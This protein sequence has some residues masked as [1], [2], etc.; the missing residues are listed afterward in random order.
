M[1]LFAAWAVCLLLGW[2]GLLGCQ[3]QPALF[4]PA[5]DP[6]ETIYFVPVREKV[7]ALTFDDGP[8]EPA[9]GLILDALKRHQVKATFFLIGANVERY[10]ETARRIKAEGHLIGNHTA[11]HSMFDQ[12][13]AFAIAQDIAD[14]Q[15]AIET[16]TGVTPLWFRPPYGIKGPGMEE[17][18]RAQGMAIAGWSAD[19][20][21]WNPHSVE[22]LVDSI[23][24]QATP[25]D[26]LLLHDGCETR[27]GA[28]RQNT[29]AAVSLILEKL[30]AQGFR[31]VTVPDLLR[32][33]GRPLA[34]FKNGA[35]LLGLQIPA[36]PLPPG[37]GFWV[38]YF[39]D[40]P[41]GGDNLTPEAFVHYTTPDGSMQFQDNHEIPRLG[42]VRDRVLKHL[43]IVP[44]KA[45]LGRYQVRFGLFDPQTPE[46]RH[47]V[48]VRSA[49]RQQRRAV[50]I[51]DVLDVN[52]AAKP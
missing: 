2:P 38:R 52:Q 29:V 1:R 34:E 48:P 17:A 14:G 15:R 51:P 39:W 12:S 28:D 16:V 47:R 33:A 24:S 49:F 19:A 21:D 31:F 50:I 44:R 11:R 13:S 4:K 18:C 36:Q 6:G 40:V 9:T 25:G 23:V 20:N 10:P 46:W 3:R 32:A 43:V 41:P 26:I 5:A 45:P 22:E 7:V 35:R 30:K 8:N 42:D 37:G 27:H